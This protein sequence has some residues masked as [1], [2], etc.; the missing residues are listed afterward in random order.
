M[1][2]VLNQ[3]NERQNG[4]MACADKEPME[5]LGG[6]G[7]TQAMVITT[8]TANPDFFYRPR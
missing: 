1:N 4:S 2:R 6:Q 3:D 8:G 5:R 7:S